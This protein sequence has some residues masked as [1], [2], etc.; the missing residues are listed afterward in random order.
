MSNIFGQITRRKTMPRAFCRLAVNPDGGAGGLKARH[1]L[2]RQS[3][4]QSCEDVAC[5]APR[6]GRVRMV[7]LNASPVWMRNEGRIIF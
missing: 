6:Q 4:D 7:M 5:P 1:T 3:R 2:R